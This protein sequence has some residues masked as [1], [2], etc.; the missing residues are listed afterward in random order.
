[1]RHRSVVKVNTRT[2]ICAARLSLPQVYSYVLLI[3]APIICDAK[4]TAC[5]L[6]QAHLELG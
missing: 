4:F 1:M 3:V 2:T 6:S 5:L